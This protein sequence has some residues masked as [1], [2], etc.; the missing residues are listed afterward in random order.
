MPVKTKAAY[1]AGPVPKESIDYFQSKGWKVGFSHLDVWKEEHA[2]AFTVAKAMEIDVLESIRGAVDSAIA[3]GTTFRDFQKTLEPTLQKLGWWGKKDVVDPKTGQKISSQLGS[4]RRLKVI[5]R[6]NIR[7]AQAAGQWDGIERTKKALPYS[8]Y[9][10]GTSEKHRAQHVAWNGLVLKADDPWWET[11]FPP[12]GWGCKCRVQQLRKAKVDPTPKD[13]YKKW[14]N[15][16]TGEIETIPEGITPGFNFNPGKARHPEQLNRLKERLNTVSPTVAEAV[17]RAWMQPKIFNRWREKPQ[18]NLPV[19]A[20]DPD[21][22][23]LMKADSRSVLLSEDSMLKQDGKAPRS[24]GHPELTDAEYCLLPD[25]LAKG[26]I[27][28]ADNQ[29]LVFYKHGTV[30]YR[31][32]TKTT[33]DGR[34]NFLLTFQRIKDKTYQAQKKKFPRV[35]K[36]D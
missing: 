5:Y 20:L 21:T 16:R 14:K 26:E 23:R 33:K 8:K 29:R 4:A 28:Q 12:N 35:R 30:R 34:E 11:H 7:S 36:E 18:G 17:H 2:Y 22:Q 25:V 13:R 9:L 15:P 27:Y 1:T 10:L 32:V 24:K 31:A 3:D 6:Q 19:A